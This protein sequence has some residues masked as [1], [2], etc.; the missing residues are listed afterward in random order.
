MNT[1]LK[2]IENPILVCVGKPTIEGIPTGGL[3]TLKWR[4]LED[5]LAMPQYPAGSSQKL[6]GNSTRLADN[7]WLFD[8]KDSLL[9]LPKFLAACRGWELRC[10]IYKIHGTVESLEDV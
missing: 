6:A 10:K 8:E 5:A 7:L 9:H 2:E 4:S 1:P 3:L